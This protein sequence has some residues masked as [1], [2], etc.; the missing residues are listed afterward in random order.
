MEKWKQLNHVE[1][2]GSK[3]KGFHSENMKVA[4]IKWL[5]RLFEENIELKTYFSIK[6][7]KFPTHI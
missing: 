7:I 5:L 2:G 1:S 3:P 4:F 6:S